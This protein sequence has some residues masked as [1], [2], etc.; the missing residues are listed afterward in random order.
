M[1]LVRRV[2]GFYLCWKPILES[3][4]KILIISAVW[5]TLCPGLLCAQAEIE[6]RTFSIFN[7]HYLAL[8]KRGV[9][10]AISAEGEDLNSQRYGS[11]YHTTLVNSNNQ[12][13]VRTTIPQH[14]MQ[15]DVDLVN[16]TNETYE[17][18]YLVLQVKNTYLQ[19]EKVAASGDWKVQ[20]AQKYI[21]SVEIQLDKD[22]VIVPIEGWTIWP[23][24]EYRDTR[25]IF[26]VEVSPDIRGNIYEYN[27][28]LHFKGVSE[29]KT[30]QVIS[31]K[32]YF[33]AS[34]P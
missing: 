29:G 11:L 15:V 31:D 7:R 18:Q 16:N 21:A 24:S 14:H 1:R 4:M 8:T 6:Y 28:T 9:L 2:C 23:A 13:E 33:I 10:P 17:L 20:M 27:L 19:A 32:T 30:L 26:E 3:E 12:R 25:F 22:Q 5:F 34:R